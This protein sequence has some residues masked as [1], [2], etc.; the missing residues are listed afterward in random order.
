MP[1]PVLARSAQSIGDPE[2][3]RKRPGLAQGDAQRLL[4]PPGL[5]QCVLVVDHTPRVSQADPRTERPDP[6]CAQSLGGEVRLVHG[7]PVGYGATD[8]LQRGSDGA[9]VD[10]DLASVGKHLGRTLIER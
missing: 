4:K 8:R 10:D 2:L 9:V 5:T 6:M 1:R 3:V 7:L